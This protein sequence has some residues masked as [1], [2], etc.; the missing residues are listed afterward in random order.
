LRL[1][2][3]TLAA[4]AALVPAGCG[5]HAG[6]A[7]PANAASVGVEAARREGRVLERGLEPLLTDALSAA[8][9]DWVD[10]PLLSP[11]EADLVVRPVLLDFARRGGVRNIDNELVESAVFVRVRAELIDRRTG[12]PVGP[13]A[14]AQEWSAYALES[15]NEDAARERAL[16]HVADTLILD[17]FEAGGGP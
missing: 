11:G 15:G 12:K 17:L 13:A 1:P 14:V 16:R 9:V 5:W 3:W 10:L 2:A 6:L 8:V 7:R 4:V